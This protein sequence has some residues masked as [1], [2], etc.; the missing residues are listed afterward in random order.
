MKLSNSF[1]EGD[2]AV[3]AFTY[4]CIVCGSN[5]D[6]EL[7]HCLGRQGKYNN[8]IL[9]SAMLCRK[10]HEKYTTLS[11]PYLL[12]TTLKLILKEGYDLKE[13]DVRFYKTNKKLYEQRII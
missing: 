5:Q 8:S 11:K 9:N 1:L 2:R 12:Q 13:R 10:C 7:H 6:C 3:Y 4:D